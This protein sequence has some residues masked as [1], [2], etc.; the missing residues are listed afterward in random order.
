MHFFEQLKFEMVNYEQCIYACMYLLGGAYVF[1]SYCPATY[2][3]VDD[4]QV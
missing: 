2:I 4:F 1:L 3:A